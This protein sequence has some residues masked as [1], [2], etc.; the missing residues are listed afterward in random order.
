MVMTTTGRKSGSPRHTAI[1]FHQ[2]KGRKYVFS[3][4]GNEA[5]WYKN[6]LA[7]P[8]VTIQT[9]E[10]TEHVVAR[11]V[12]R[13]DELTEAFELVERNPTMRRWVRLLGVQLT[14]DDFIA[15]KDSYHLL[16]FDPAN[17]PTPPPLR[18]DLWWVWL[19][20]LAALLAGWYGSPQH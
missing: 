4:W 5:D 8:S 7:D 14:E 18:V 16:T 6:I 15:H 9:T 13:D 11:R 20:V 2:H 12:T 3:A 17:E 10:G 19:L 1:E